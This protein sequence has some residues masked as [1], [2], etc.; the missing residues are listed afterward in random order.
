MRRSAPTTAPREGVAGVE[1]DG[2][3]AAAPDAGDVAVGEGPGGPGAASLPARRPIPR[4]A[5]IALGVLL[6]V[7]LLVA[8][9]QL[10]R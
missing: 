4:S 8:A 1:S 3:P 5:M 10:Y 7:A 6:V 2:G 9:L